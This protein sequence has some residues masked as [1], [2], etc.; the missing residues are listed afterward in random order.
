LLGLEKVP[1]AIRGK[2]EVFRMHQAI[3]LKNQILEISFRLGNNTAVLS[4]HISQTPSHRQTRS[5]LTGHPDSERAFYLVKWHRIGLWGLSHPCLLRSGVDLAICGYHS[6]CLVFVLR[7]VVSS[8]YQDRQ[9]KFKL[10]K[11]EGF[12]IA[13]IPSDHELFLIIDHGESAATFLDVKVGLPFEFVLQ[14]VKCYF[15]N[16]LEVF[17][18]DFLWF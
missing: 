3:L 2:H 5:Q 13:R 14:A 8:L 7:L 12:W 11:K 4:V 10:P 16:F 15:D 9:V 1:H 18:L 17:G 6:R